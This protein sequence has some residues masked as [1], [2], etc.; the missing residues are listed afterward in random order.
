M[1]E[2]HS[3]TNRIFFDTIGISNIDTYIEL[4]RARWLEKLANMKHDGIPRKLLGSWIPLPRKNGLSGR[5][6]QTI[7]HAY[8][9]TLHTLGFKNTDFNSWMTE[10]NNRKIWGKRVEHFLGLPEGSY[11]RSNAKNKAAAL[12]SYTDLQ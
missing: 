6:Q 11:S 5:P 7:R 9:K 10:A 1:I 2:D 8:V 4:R 3:L 12:K